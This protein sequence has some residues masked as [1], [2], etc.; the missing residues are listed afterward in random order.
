M[1]IKY[2]KSDLAIEKI[3]DVLTWFD[4]DEEDGIRACK[5]IRDYVEKLPSADVV[6]VVRCKD[7]KYRP[8]SIDGATQG[9]DVWFAYDSKCPCECDDGWYNWYPKDDWFCANGER[10]A[11]AEIY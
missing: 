8:K 11:D 3:I 6:E 9:F 5:A 10:R 1:A 4:A 7:C 2:I